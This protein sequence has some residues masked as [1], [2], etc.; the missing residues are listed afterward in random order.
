[1]AGQVVHARAGDRANYRPIRSPLCAGADPVL[2][3]RA[4]LALAPFDALY[5]AD[6]DA[7][8]HHGSAP[9]LAVHEALCG[10]LGARRGALWLDAGWFDGGAAPWR[11]ALRGAAQRA[12]AQ[13]VWVVGSE[14]LAAAVPIPAD[15]VLSLD[16]RSGAFLGPVGLDA[17]PQAWPRRVI[18]ME[19]SAVGTDR[20]PALATLQVLRR[21][22]AEAGRTD[23]A[24]F[25]AG[26][27]RDAQDLRQ[28]GA[29]PVG[30]VLL[31]SALHCGRLDGATLRQLL[32]ERDAAP[33]KMDTP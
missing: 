1:M 21:R 23:V 12:G 31:A 18:A 8:M 20:G 19:L 9:D 30:G 7:I 10:L 29:L 27:V 26:G 22:A 25:A 5:V 24:F 15:C 6:L 2:L 4:L 28:L 14:S 32:L 11:G 17:S 3:A 33:K 13:L 16:Y